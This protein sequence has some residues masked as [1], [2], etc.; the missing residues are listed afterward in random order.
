MQRTAY[1][2]NSKE[3]SQ[4]SFLFHGE[5]R[6]KSNDPTTALQKCLLHQGQRAKNT[7][8]GRRPTVG[9]EMRLTTQ[10]ASASGKTYKA[11]HLPKKV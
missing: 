4:G 11:V 5:I 8:V 3:Q 10:V 7:W 6:G 9:H 2:W 1:T